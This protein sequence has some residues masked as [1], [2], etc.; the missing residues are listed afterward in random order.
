MRSIE[1]LLT[2]VPLDIIAIEAV[3]RQSDIAVRCVRVKAWRI[4]WGGGVWLFGRTAQDIGKGVNGLEYHT[5]SVHLFCYQGSQRIVLEGKHGQERLLTSDAISS[6]HLS[7]SLS[8]F[9]SF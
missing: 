9:V 8:P 5:R 3:A 7:E 4:I 2:S 6:E 1:Q